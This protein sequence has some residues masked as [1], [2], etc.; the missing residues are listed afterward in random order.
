MQ[1]LIEEKFPFLDE[2]GV[3]MVYKNVIDLV[4]YQSVR[5]FLKK[6]SWI[7]SIRCPA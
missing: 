1:E 5:R 4:N 3:A 6:K 2:D 7:E